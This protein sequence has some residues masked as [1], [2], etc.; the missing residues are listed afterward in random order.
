M[1]ELAPART[2][3]RGFSIT[4][5]AAGAVLRDPAA[6]AAGSAI[7]TELAGGLLYSRVE[8]KR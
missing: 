5:D 7:E 8:E 6:V 2:L 4:R 3:R 1:V